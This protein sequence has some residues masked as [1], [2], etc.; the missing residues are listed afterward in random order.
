M[1][2]DIYILAMHDKTFLNN[3]QVNIV[4][5]TDFLS[6]VSM[7]IRLCCVVDVVEV[8]GNSKDVGFVV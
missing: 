3:V 7:K 4:M 5:K 6:S 1:D 2:V 8:C